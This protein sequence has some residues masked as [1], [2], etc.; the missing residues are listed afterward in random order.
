MLI[1]WLL[2]VIAS[3]CILW[4]S[5]LFRK[6]GEGAEDAK[7]FLWL[8]LNGLAFAA[9]IFAVYAVTLFAP[10]KYLL[11]L[12]PAVTL[13]LMGIVLK[14]SAVDIR[15][16][17]VGSRNQVRAG[18]VGLL[19][20][21][22]SY[23][24]VTGVVWFVGNLLFYLFGIEVQEQ[25]AYQLIKGF[26]GSPL[27]FWYLTIVVVIIVPFVE[28]LLFRGFFQGFAKRIFQPTL[29][30]ICSG[31]L[32]AGFHVTPSQGGWNIAL[33][34][35]L[36]LFGYIAA[37]LKEQENAIIAPVLAHSA[38]NCISVMLLLADK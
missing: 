6:S 28:E 31:L 36:T 21:L 11:L 3:I 13:A 33:L 9:F 17:I 25:Q 37:R 10:Q 30:P 8:S 14:I 26:S 29:V 23:P 22:V 35:G 24:A 16:E 34:V 7:F 32:F 15:R 18:L 19:Y 38:F 20:G 1:S 12:T 5:P 2:L 27:L 4:L